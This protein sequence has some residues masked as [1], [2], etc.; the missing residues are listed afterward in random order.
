MA[1]ARSAE[2]LEARMAASASSFSAVSMALSSDVGIL[3]MDWEP[4]TAG[5]ALLRRTSTAEF[6]LGLESAV[7]RTAAADTKKPGA[8]SRPGT[9]REFQFPEYTD[10]RKRVNP[11]GG[12]RAN[13]RVVSRSRAVT[14]RRRFN[15]R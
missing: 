11:S 15:L 1:W 7:S 2:S 10:L 5:S 14:R 3:G 6:Q 8:V 13:T 4:R 9:L 12:S